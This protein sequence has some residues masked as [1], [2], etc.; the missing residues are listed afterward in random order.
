CQSN[1]DTKVYYYREDENRS[2]Y[3]RNIPILSFNKIVTTIDLTAQIYITP[4]IDKKNLYVTGVDR[5]LFT[6]LNQ[7][8]SHIWRYR[9][10]GVVSASPVSYNSLIFIPDNEGNLVALNQKTGTILWKYIANAGIYSSPI[11]K[12]DILH[13]ASTDGYYHK[14]NVKNGEQ[15]IKVKM[16]ESV[17]S[18][19]AAINNYIIF[20]SEK[21]LVICYKNNFTSEHIVSEPQWTFR[22]S[23][24]DLLNYTNPVIFNNRVFISSR[25]G[26][27][28]CLDL[29]SGKL[30]WT[31]TANDM[32]D[33]APAINQNLV[34]VGS[35]D[36]NVY[37][38][39]QMNGQLV[40]SYKTDSEV[41][42]P[43]LTSS[44]VVYVGLKNG[45]LLALNIKSGSLL[46]DFQTK[47][48]IVASPVLHQDRLIF[49]S[50]DHSVYIL[51]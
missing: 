31:F 26:N 13:F 37:A 2:G 42:S 41:T 16:R 45:K 11:I 32:I 5:L 39:D 34:I 22:A 18:S 43:A 14:V 24:E 10:L 9:T 7:T 36:K 12:N 23:N 46:W 51:E 27:V 20:Y 29:I 38:L 47:D 50:Y 3:S 28:H 4:L 33:V 49:G 1:Q 44:R 8:Y 15:V 6:Y 21:G 17:Y 40:W 19:P 48:A 30:I 35:Y 25:D